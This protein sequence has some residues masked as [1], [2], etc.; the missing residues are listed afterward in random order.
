M[1]AITTR[2]QTFVSYAGAGQST[3][4][5]PFELTAGIWAADFSATWGGGTVTLQK[6][7]GDGSTYVTALTA[8]TA[9]GTAFGYIPKGTYKLAI[10]TATAVY[11]QLTRVDRGD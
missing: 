9:N 8:W 7:A 3:D 5:D 2:N 6:L 10:T 1:A 4:S 11:V